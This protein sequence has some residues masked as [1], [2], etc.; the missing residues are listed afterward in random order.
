MGAIGVCLETFF[1]DL[2]YRQRLRRLAEL[3]FTRYE[4]WFHDKRFDGSRL[5][6]EPKDFAEIAAL[7]RELGL[8]CTDFIFNH[9]DGGIRASMIDQRDRAQLLE[10]LPPM[11][12]LARQIGCP[13]FITTAG[14]VVSGLG[15]TAAMEAMAESL[16]RAA[17]ICEPEG[18]TLLLEPFNTR[19]DH[20]QYFLDDPYDGITVLEQV[21]RPG[22]RMLYDI[23]HAQ[24]MA[25]DIV[26]FIRRN[27]RWIAH[28]HVAGVPGRHEPREGELNYPFI[29]GELR[30]LGYAGGVGLEYWP[31]RDP[32][33]SLRE[34]RAWLEGSIDGP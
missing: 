1:T 18:I 23:Y 21:N 14:N 15:R 25:G 3:G 11:I 19:V 20:P 6:D 31:T 2:D 7:N 10:S 27:L 22:V 30:R 5:F 32:A 28:V 34:T 9:P 13:A 4:F 24:I 26:A 12:A 16:D 33:Q 17:R 29:L 8:V